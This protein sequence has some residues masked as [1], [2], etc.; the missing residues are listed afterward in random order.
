MDAIPTDLIM[1]AGSGRD[2]LSSLAGRTA[3]ANLKP[4]SA[5]GGGTMAAAAREAIFTDAL[6]AAVH[7]RLEELRSVTK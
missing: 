6:L 2:R 5:V 1:A 3:A 7:A 4:G